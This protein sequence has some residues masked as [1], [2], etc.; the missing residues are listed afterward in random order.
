[1]TMF[2]SPSLDSSYDEAIL[3]PLYFKPGGLGVDVG[4]NVGNHTV[5]MA[6]SMD[7]VFSLEPD[8]DNF[9]ALLHNLAEGQ[10]LNV[11]PIAVAAGDEDKLVSFVAAGGQSRRSGTQSVFNPANHK[12]FLVVQQRLDSLLLQLKRVDF[13]KIDVEGMEAEVLAGARQAIAF[14]RPDVLVENHEQIEPGYGAKLED[15]VEIMNGLGYAGF[16]LKPHL[17]LFKPMI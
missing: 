3:E 8:P 15:S 2:I 17:V 11:S 6:R 9:A 16:A 14:F 13:I 1:V 12:T 7:H 5:A 10:I 4:A